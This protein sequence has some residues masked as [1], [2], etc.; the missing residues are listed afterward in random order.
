ME[1]KARKKELRQALNRFYRNPMAKVSLELFLTLGL[2]LFLAIFVVK[3]TLTTMSELSKEIEEKEKLDLDLKKKLTALRTTQDQL[4]LLAPQLPLLDEAIPNSPSVVYNMKLVEKVVADTN[5]LITGGSMKEIPDETTEI[6]SSDTL[7][8]KDIPVSI[9]V[10][11]DYQSIRTFVEQLQNSRRA[12]VVDTVVFNIEE[13]RGS[14]QLR[15]TVTL[16][17]PYLSDEEQS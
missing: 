11:G 12:V 3:P 9:S 5:T 6:T 15:A 10:I 1:S 16:S 13:Q 7:S 17:F 2:A 8:R 4:D 14:R